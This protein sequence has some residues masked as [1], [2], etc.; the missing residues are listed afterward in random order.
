MNNSA[1]V[2][3]DINQQKVGGKQRRDLYCLLLSPYCIL[4]MGR[5]DKDI[6]S[7]A[8]TDRVEQKTHI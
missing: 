6:F 7:T 8:R 5:H 3:F 2:R 4:T 1:I